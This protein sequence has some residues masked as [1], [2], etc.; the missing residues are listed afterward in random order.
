MLATPF[1][2][3]AQPAR[4]VY[5]LGYLT[6]T[7]P[8]TF[9]VAVFRQALGD[10]GWVEGRNL[11]ID[12]RSAD[13]KFERLPGLAAELIRLKPDLIVAIATVSALAAQKTT[14][15]IPIVFAYVSDAVGSGLVEGLARPAANVT[16]LTHHNSSLNPKRLEFLQHAMPKATV[17]AG[18][19]QPGGLGQHTE[20]LMLQETEAAA[21]ALGMRLRLVEARGA[22]DLEAAFATA[23]GA[24]PDALFV[25]PAPVF[26]SNA[27]RVVDLVARG[28][29]PA[30]YFG[31]E[32]PDVGGL[33]SYGA[34]MANILQGA[35]SYV[36]RILKGAR[37]SDL[38]VERG[39][40]F[41]FVINAKT[42]KA[43][44]LT[45][46]ASLLARADEVIE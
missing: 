15:D 25:L 3:H 42:A 13:G 14:R 31:R 1:A 20:R 33:M 24:H 4:R 45:I 43:L 17:V 7:A 29:L 12:Y 39:S 22:G 36:D 40:K 8:E 41:E 16:G 26:R 21:T 5:R 19:W 6:P 27:R 46:P 9:G 32:F 34:D 30:M 38:P 35:A 2:A 11:L 44:G 23:S 28:R 10:L 18:L 37:P